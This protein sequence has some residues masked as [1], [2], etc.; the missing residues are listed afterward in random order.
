M[1][2]TILRIAAAALAFTAAAAACQQTN[3]AQPRGAG[4]ELAA[5][6]A[7]MSSPEAT[8]KLYLASLKS[9]DLETARACLVPAM[10]PILDAL[11]QGGPAKLAS[12]ADSFTGFAMLQGAVTPIRRRTGCRPDP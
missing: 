7:R 4:K 6:D 2:T 3:S 11:A 5:A 9:G 8:W 10:H 12:I 1:Q